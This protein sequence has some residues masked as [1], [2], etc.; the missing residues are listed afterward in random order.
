MI[1]RLEPARPLSVQVMDA[2]RPL[3]GVEVELLDP[4]G[5]PVLAATPTRPGVAMPLFLAAETAVLLGSA[6]TGADGHA[7]VPLL[8][9][10]MPLAI[11]LRGDG[12]TTTVRTAPFGPGSGAGDDPIVCEIANGGTVEVHVAGAGEHRLVHLLLA[13]GE[14]DARELHPGV[15]KAVAPDGEGVARFTHVPPGTWQVR[16]QRIDEA[17]LKDGVAVPSTMAVVARETV[18]CDIDLHSLRPA[19]LA[20]TVTGHDDGELNLQRLAGDEVEHAW[21]RT[22]VGGHFTLAELFPGRYRLLR[23]GDGAV[24]D[25]ELGPGEVL[26]TPL[27]L[28]AAPGG[29]EPRAR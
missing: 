5:R 23:G 10:R 17:F 25:F 1:L 14:G 8:E 28:R 22:P 19:S 21:R 26:R 16:V 29:T 4:C 2:G 3:G 27:A 13:R 18:R 24:A 12:I 20:L 6:V 15:A 9:D 11:R 7:R